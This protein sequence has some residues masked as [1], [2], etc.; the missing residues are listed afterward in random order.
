MEEEKGGKVNNERIGREE[1]ILQEA[2]RNRDRWRWSK[3]DNKRGEEE[4]MGI[5]SNEIMGGGERGN[6]E[7]GEE[8]K[9]EIGRKERM[10]KRVKGDNGRGEEEKGGEVRNERMGE[11]ERGNNEI[12]EGE[13]REIGRKE[14]IVGEMKGYN[15]EREMGGREREHWGK[16]AWRG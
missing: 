2:K 10:G 14:I 15:E 7:K 8:E 4:K 6:N 13:K 9:R 12:G 11:G 3:T 16:R 1:D 5:V